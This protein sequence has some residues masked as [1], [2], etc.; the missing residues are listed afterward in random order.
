MDK[1]KFSGTNILGFSII[2]FEEIEFRQQTGKISP[3]SFSIFIST[4]VTANVLIKLSIP[5]Y[6]LMPSNNQ[7]A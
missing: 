6:D 3:V 5:K 2:N 7:F 4:R 1:L